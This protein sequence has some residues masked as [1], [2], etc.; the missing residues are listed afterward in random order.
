MALEN[1]LSSLLG[2]GVTIN[3]KGETGSMVIH[4]KT[5]EQ[6]DDLIQRLSRGSL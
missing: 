2:L 6:L 5:L 3:T 4:F 1:D